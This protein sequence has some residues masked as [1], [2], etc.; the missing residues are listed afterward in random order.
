MTTARTTQGPVGQC[1]VCA[2]KEPSAQRPEAMEQ[3]KALD[4]LAECILLPHYI[5]YWVTL[6]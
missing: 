6:P 2:L 5:L 4:T 3:L 1:D